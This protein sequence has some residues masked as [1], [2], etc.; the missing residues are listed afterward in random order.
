MG[1][2]VNEE[3]ERGAD[4]DPRLKIVCKK[5][6]GTSVFRSL[7]R[8]LARSLHDA[9]S[10][11]LILPRIPFYIFQLARIDR[12]PTLLTNERDGIKGLHR[13]G[14]RERE[15]AGEQKEKNAE[16]ARSARTQAFVVAFAVAPSAC[17]A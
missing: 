3:R 5:K 4:V 14:E 10:F 6:S 17:S 16:T 13:E 7:A 2:A 8:S 11:R 1:A 9:A 15:R 12:S